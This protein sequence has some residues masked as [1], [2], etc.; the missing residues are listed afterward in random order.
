M[1]MKQLRWAFAAGLIVV[2]MVILVACEGDPTDE[3]PTIPQAVAVTENTLQP[4][5]RSTT[6]Q[7]TATLTPSMT[8]TPSNTPTASDTATPNTP[9]ATVTNTSTPPA[10]GTVFSTEAR[11][12][13]REGPGREYPEVTRVESGTVVQILG[14]DESSTREIWYQIRLVEEDGTIRQGW[15]LG[16]LIQTDAIIPTTGPTPTD[17]PTSIL[18]A[19]TSA[20]FATAEVSGTAIVFNTGTPPASL[21]QVN[22]WAYCNIYNGQAQN[23]FPRTARS[24]QT[25]SLYWSWFVTRPE[26]MADHQNAVDYDVRIN[27][28]RLENWDQYATELRRDSRNNNYWTIYWYVPL[29]QL[30][31]GEY[32]VEY[33]ATWSQ[34][35]NDGLQDYGPGTEN[36]E[37][38]GSCTFTITE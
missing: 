31:P 33:R 26:L 25:V 17:T 4:A 21:S 35:V 14:S 34:V 23:L 29:G 19:G 9:T 15:M 3:P 32:T 28:R 10:E 38:V 13:V 37:D 5:L 1:L 24:D 2:L 8:F 27:N 16:R 6:P 11:V 7:F 22:I 30:E 36:T 12:L 20:P 18:T